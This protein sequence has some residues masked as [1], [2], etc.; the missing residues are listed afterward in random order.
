MLEKL[1]PEE[2]EMEVQVKK[3]VHQ[4]FWDV[5]KLELSED[6]PVFHRALSLLEDVRTA[7]VIFYKLI[8]KISIRVGVLFK[9]GQS[10]KGLNLLI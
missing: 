7:L 10:K 6:P 1:K 3:I 5:L 4:A 8:K 9:F 2:S